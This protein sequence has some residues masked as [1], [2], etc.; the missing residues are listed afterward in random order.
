MP[1][2]IGAKWYMTY[3]AYNDSPDVSATN[4]KKSEAGQSCT[5]SERYLNYVTSD[6]LFGPYNGP[7]RHLILSAGDA[8]ESTQQGIC[9][10]KVECPAN[11]EPVCMR[12]TGAKGAG[13]GTRK[14]AYA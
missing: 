8:D 14:E 3:V 11:F 2:K 1:V 4:S 13:D 6:S 12:E 9:E 5:T 10:Y 7:I